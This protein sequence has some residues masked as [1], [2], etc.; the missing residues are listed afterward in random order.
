MFTMSLA[1]KLTMGTYQYAQMLELKDDIQHLGQLLVRGSLSTAENLD[2]SSKKK[3]YRI[4]AIISLVLTALSIPTIVLFCFKDNL[5]LII[6]GY[7]TQAL[8]SAAGFVIVS[9]LMTFSFSTLLIA[10]KKEDLDGLLRREK[11]V[12]LLVFLAFTIAYLSKAFILVFDVITES[13][14]T[15]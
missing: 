8:Y 13:S 4:A 1:A 9:I 11:K 12:L 2:R 14:W 3:I 5:T 10:I 7:A 6:Y 15:D